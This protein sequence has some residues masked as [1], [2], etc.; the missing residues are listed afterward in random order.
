MALNDLTGKRFG[1]LLVT[2]RGHNTEQGRATWLC[3]CDCGN[4]KAVQAVNLTR[5]RGTTRS[6]GCTQI[7][8]R[9]ANGDLIG[10][11][12]DHPFSRRH[13][14]REHKAW[15]NMIARCT[16]PDHVSYFAYGARGIS[17]CPEWLASF[18]RFATDMGPC[19]DKY[20][21]ERKDSQCNYSAD[22][23][24]W[25]SRDAQANNRSSNRHI[26]AFG[27]TQTVAQ[28]AKEKSLPYAYIHYRVFRKH[29]DPEVVMA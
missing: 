6:C 7:E 10:K 24:C 9:K 28:W 8:S 3:A 19:P 5:T 1:K 14:Y 22:N 4:T 21:L 17:V 20:T 11:R 18:E 13:M 29:L 26:T 27:K 16:N 23:C 25:A 15:E 12:K 2:A